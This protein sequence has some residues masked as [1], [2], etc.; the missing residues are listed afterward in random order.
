M[1]GGAFR[2]AHPFNRDHMSVD[3]CGANNTQHVKKFGSLCRTLLRPWNSQSFANRGGL[4]ERR[5]ACTLARLLLRDLHGKEPRNNQSTALEGLP[6]ASRRL[7]NFP[8]VAWQC[9]SN[10]EFCLPPCIAMP[11]ALL[12]CHSGAIL[13]GSLV[14]YPALKRCVACVCSARN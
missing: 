4:L 12:D 6:A 13:L 2:I 5:V 7:L 8:Q 3:G 11:C 1:I 10:C 14:P 9:T